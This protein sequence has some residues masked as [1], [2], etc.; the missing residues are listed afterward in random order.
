MR[1]WLP[2]P[3]VRLMVR[4]LRGRGFVVFYLAPEDRVCRDGVCWLQL[5]ESI[6]ER[7]DG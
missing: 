6:Q 1:W 7:G 5:Y 3:V 4:C 2:G